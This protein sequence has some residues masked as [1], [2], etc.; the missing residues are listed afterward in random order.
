[1]T[2]SNVK[3]PKRAQIELARF[4][5]E[6][7]AVRLPLSW[8]WDKR[9]IDSL[10]YIFT[11]SV[12]VTALDCKV[13]DLVLDFASGSGW[14]SEWLNRLGYRVVSVDISTVL[15]NFSRKRLAMDTRI[16]ED[17]I[18]AYFVAGDSERLPF[19]DGTF[20]GVLCLNSLHHMPDY[21]IIF[22]EIFRVL[23]KDGRASFAEP[24]REHSKAAGSQKEMEESGVL[25]RDVVLSDIHELAQEAGFEELTLKP[26]F[27][28]VV[29]DY[30]Y[31]RWQKLLKKEPGAVNGYVERLCNYVEKANLIFTLH[32]SK[33]RVIDSRKP[34]VLKAA[35]DV[36]GVPQ[37]ARP[38]EVIGIKA[39]VKN[40]GDTLWLSEPRKMGGH[41]T[42]GIKLLSPE[43]GSVERDYARGRL[44]K[45]LGPGETV[46]FPVR[47]RA[48]SKAG[49]YTLTFDMVCE[50]VSW[51]SDRGNAPVS[52]N[53]K[54]I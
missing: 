18:P 33:E 49:Q 46:E 23:K 54:V 28:P 32:K 8:K 36:S 4:Y 43:E 2:L 37:E 27:H 15:L 24:G 11:F 3:D 31:S 40:K 26:Y 9:Y 53:I 42:L 17:G 1:M 29:E 14:S 47:F 10:P 51:F 45:D 21:R 20:D 41:V 44:P 12:A 34:G 16:V 30:T 5:D 50:G 6:E 19:R 52:I 39:R 38:G 25:E 22:D 35:L 13:G 48:P 7:I